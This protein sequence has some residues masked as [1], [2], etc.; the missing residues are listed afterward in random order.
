MKF[1]QIYLVLAFIIVSGC[2]T[3]QSA[4]DPVEG[5]L[6]LTVNITGIKDVNGVIRV[7]LYNGKSRWLNVKQAVRGRLQF[8]QSSE[9]Q[10]TF[11][12]LAAGEYAVAVFQD[13]NLNNKMDKRW[14]FIPS[15]PFGFSNNTVKRTSV[16]P[17][18]YKKAKFTL[19]EDKEIDIN[20][21]KI[22]K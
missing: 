12:G 8:I 15:E 14:W 9:E 3:Q 7:A 10:L 13:E 6:S 4:V 19:D 20:L 21:I 2:A 11:H 16:G 18:S 17:P 22:F 5:E 1:G